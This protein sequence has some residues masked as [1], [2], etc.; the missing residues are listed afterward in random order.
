MEGIVED[1]AIARSL[2]QPGITSFLGVEF[3]ENAL[4]IQTF[5]GLVLS[6]FSHLFVVAWVSSSSVG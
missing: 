3:W 6:W 5:W 1:P 4:M 2:I